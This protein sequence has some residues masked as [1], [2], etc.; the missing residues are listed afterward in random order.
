MKNKSV[1]KLSAGIAVIGAAL[2]LPVHA[3][4]AKTIWT[5]TCAACHGKDGKGNTKMG[6]KVD[7]KDYTD[8]K[9]QAE[10]KDDQA[11]KTIKQGLKDDKGKERMKPYD[12]L[13]DEEAKSL[14]AYMRE[15]KA[16]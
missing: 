12:Q 16:K 9:V 3:E 8:A 2:S 1:I 7:V 10:M 5:K 11:V 4:D 13:T 14:V 15:F 6:K